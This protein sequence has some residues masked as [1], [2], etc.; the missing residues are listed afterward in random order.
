MR[1]AEREQGQGAKFSDAGLV[2]LAPPAS[3]MA[4]AGEQI[5]PQGDTQLATDTISST[6]AEHPDRSSNPHTT[7]ALNLNENLSALII[8]FTSINDVDISALRTLQDLLKDCKE[9]RLKLIFAG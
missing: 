3:G 5:A 7:E 9:R 1:C 8:D 2:G 4:E 6:A